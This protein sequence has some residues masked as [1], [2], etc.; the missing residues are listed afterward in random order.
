MAKLSFTKFGFK[1]KN[2]VTTVEFNGIVIEIKQYLP[3]NDKLKLIS[4]IINLSADPE[5]NYA[6][7][8]KIEVFKVLEI[9]DFYT[10]ISFTD[11][12]KEDPSKLYDL[13]I[14]NGL[15][16]CILENFNDGEIGNLNWAIDSSIKAIYE[17]RNS[18]LGILE[19]ISTDYSNLNLDAT[20]I[21][22]ELADPD[23]MELLK[24]VL[25]KLG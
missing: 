16:R 9:I 24:G 20:K 1:P 4:N 18:M 11:K 14:A 25:T 12:Q 6:N 2:D 3:V 5:V 21:Q 17:H 15:W 8:L 23:N 19:T 10:N 13:I 7:P 22:Q